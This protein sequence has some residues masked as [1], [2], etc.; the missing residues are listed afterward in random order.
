MEFVVHRLG[1][2]EWLIMNACYSSFSCLDHA[3]VMECV[4]H[5]CDVN[6]RGFARPN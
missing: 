4:V 1:R 6:K 3:M 5:G 2:G